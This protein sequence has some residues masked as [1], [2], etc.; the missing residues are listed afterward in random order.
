MKNTERENLE[1]SDK[2]EAG[3]T[4]KK[5]KETLRTKPDKPKERLVREKPKPKTERR[6][7]AESG[8]SNKPD[9]KQET[10]QAHQ[11]PKKL[12]SNK[13]EATYNSENP[14]GAV[15]SKPEEDKGARKRNENDSA[16]KERKIRNKDRPAIQIY[17]PGAKRM[18]GQKSVS[19]L[20]KHVKH[21]KIT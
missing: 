2:T 10:Q 3:A 19:Q 4:N 18:T 11:H 12:V 16:E 9:V 7:A 21:F 14:T 20:S 15:S 1:K 6:P 13:E 8:E 5:I 17:R